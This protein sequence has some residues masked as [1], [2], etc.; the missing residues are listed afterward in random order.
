MKHL[1]LLFLSLLLVVTGSVSLQAQAYEWVLTSVRIDAIP[2]NAG[3]L[4]TPDMYMIM[5]QGTNVQFTSGT[6]DDMDPP[7]TFTPNVTVDSTLMYTIE[8]WDEDAIDSDDELGIVTIPGKGTGD[9]TGTVGG[10]TGQLDVH[11]EYTLVVGIEDELVAVNLS[12]GPNPAQ[13]QIFLN[14][15]MVKVVDMQVQ[16]IDMQGRIVQEANLGSQMGLQQYPLAVSELANGVYSLRINAGGA[17]L[18][19]KI[20]VNH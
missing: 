15:E 9:V 3:F 11:Y 4:D 8:V 2:D 1:R 19:H 14:L 16:L 6:F 20:I 18:N 5:K 13:D 10:A 7:V 12:V 17:I